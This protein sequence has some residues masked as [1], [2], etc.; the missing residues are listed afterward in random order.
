MVARRGVKWRNDRPRRGVRKTVEGQGQTP[1]SIRLGDEVEWSSRLVSCCRA[2]DPINYR[3]SSLPGHEGLE[4]KSPTVPP[5][6]R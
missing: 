3:K 5:P 6:F 1:P 4:A 2:G